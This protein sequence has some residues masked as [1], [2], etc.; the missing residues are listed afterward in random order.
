[1]QRA[2]WLK[3]QTNAPGFSIYRQILPLIVK[4][5]KRSSVVNSL[6]TPSPPP[7]FKVTYNTDHHHQQRRPPSPTAQTTITNSAD[8]HHQQRRPTSPTQ[9]L[10]LKLDHEARAINTCYEKQVTLTWR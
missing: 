7:Q 8:H 10:L 6:T 9:H 3:D 1:L 5:M 2:F 4:I